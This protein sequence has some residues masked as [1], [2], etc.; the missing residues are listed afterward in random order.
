[1]ETLTFVARH[2][3]AFAMSV[4]AALIVSGAHAQTDAGKKEIDLAFEAASKAKQDGP[5]SISLS[6]QAS[7]KIPAQQTYVPMPAAGT[8][9][10]AMGNRPDDRLQGIVLPLGQENWMVVVKFEKS[11]YVKDDDAR[12]WNADDLL[13]SLKEGTESS[14]EDRKQRGLPEIEVVGWAEKPAYDA[15]T[16]RLVWAAISRSKGTSDTNTGVNYNT[17]ALGRDGYMSLNLVTGLKELESQKPIARTL[18][19]NLEFS[20]GKRYADF[21]AS[22]DK[23][24][25]YGLAALVAGVAAKKLGL[26]ALLA[27][28]ALK[29]WKVGAL[30]LVGL[31]AVLPKIFKRKPPAA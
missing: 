14:N 20:G 9:M 7:L 27:V 21:N 17:Y 3:R 12:D 10:R 26:F 29:F 28:W 4:A 16:H 6:D 22:T 19:A 18:L 2:C 11:G 25:E 5:A 1:M 15:T 31:A 30:A 24:A 23:V 8:L 13:K